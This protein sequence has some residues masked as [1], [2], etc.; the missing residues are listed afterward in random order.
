[1]V[2]HDVVDEALTGSVISAYYAVYNTLGYG[3]LEHVYVMALERELRE[4]HHSVAREV[5][6][7][8]RYRGEVL[9]MQRIDMV[10]D[11]RLVVETTPD[12]HGHGAVIRTIREIRP[13]LPNPGLCG[14]HGTRSVQRAPCMRNGP[15]RSGGADCSSG[16]I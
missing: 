5:G 15:S 11:G 13:I 8:I 12:Q 4:R 16:P 14:L 9:A 10:V 2:P 3:F 1:M 7:P 6:V